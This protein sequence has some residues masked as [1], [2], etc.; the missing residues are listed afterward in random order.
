MHYV[1][2]FGESPVYKSLAYKHCCTYKIQSLTKV[3]VKEIASRPRVRNGSPNLE[4][5]VGNRIMGPRWKLYF[6]EFG[7]LSCQPVKR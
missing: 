2:A 5:I 3:N 7:Q 4:L 1:I 6:F